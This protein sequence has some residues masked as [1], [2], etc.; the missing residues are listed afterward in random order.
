[1]RNWRSL[2][3]ILVVAFL[4]VHAEDWP[5]WRGPSMNGISNE[6]DLPLHWLSLIHI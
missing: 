3:V 5:Q 2:A 1:M 6:K 4:P